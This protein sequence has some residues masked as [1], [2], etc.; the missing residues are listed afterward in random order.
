QD[1]YWGFAAFFGRLKW[2]RAAGKPGNIASGSAW[3]VK[4]AL[5][6]AG[7]VRSPQPHARTYA[8]PRPLDG[9]ELTVPPGEDPRRQLADWLVGQPQFAR[10]VVNRYWAHFLGRGLVD[11]V[12]DFRVTNP[13]SNPELLDALARDFVAHKFDLKHL[14]RVICASKTYQLSSVA[15]KLNKD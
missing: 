10:A 1:D 11:P 2:E 12:D 9:T 4:I 8:N 14:I 15:D 3:S 6:N 13:P 5:Q 7:A